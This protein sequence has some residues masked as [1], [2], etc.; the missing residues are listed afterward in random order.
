MTTHT[1]LSLLTYFRKSSGKNSLLTDKSENVLMRR[2]ELKKDN[3][4]HNFFSLNFQF[5]LNFFHEWVGCFEGDRDVWCFTDTIVC[6]VFR[7]LC[8]SELGI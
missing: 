6:T 3:N 4:K 1:T 2:Q 5:S 7:L 8:F